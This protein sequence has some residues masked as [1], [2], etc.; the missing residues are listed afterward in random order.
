M[1]VFQKNAFAVRLSIEQLTMFAS[2]D[3]RRKVD[4]TEEIPVPEQEWDDYYEAVDLLERLRHY[5]CFDE[6]G[7]DEGASI[8]EPRPLTRYYYA[9]T[10]EEWHA[11]VWAKLDA[12]EQPDNRLVD[13]FV[14]DA[15]T[16]MLY[17]GPLAAQAAF[18]EAH[19]KIQGLGKAVDYSHHPIEWRDPTPISADAVAEAIREA[20]HLDA[21]DG[22]CAPAA[23]PWAGG[24]IPRGG[25]ANDDPP[26]LAPDQQGV[27][28]RPE[29]RA[30][31]GGLFFE[32][33]CDD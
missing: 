33:E 3:W 1:P 20:H 26:F 9:E 19:T 5:D 31:R 29:A 17:D 10:E 30:N 13:S 28:V 2:G 22:K 12:G 23:G 6:G 27:Q 24:T 25:H 11:R 15:F 16:E 18:G 21:F 14:A 7:S 8:E 4:Y 32:K